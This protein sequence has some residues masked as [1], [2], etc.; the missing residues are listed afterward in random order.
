LAANSYPILLIDAVIQDEI[1]QEYNTLS[2]ISNSLLEPLASRW[3]GYRQVF[4][5]KKTADVVGD[6]LTAVIKHT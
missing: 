1:W 2:M 6:N 5:F 3:V 4:V